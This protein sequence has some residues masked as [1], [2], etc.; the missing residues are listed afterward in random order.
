MTSIQVSL[1]ET[2]AEFVQRQVMAG[3][4]ST[5]SE[6]LGFLVEQ[7]RALAERQKLD[8]LLEEGMRSGDPM[9]FS[10]EWWQ[11]KKT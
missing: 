8:N 6:Y 3:Q 1:A 4:F 7:A 9:P 5:P 10:S 2:A 11:T